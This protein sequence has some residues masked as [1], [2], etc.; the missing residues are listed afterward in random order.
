VSIGNSVTSIGQSAFQSCSGLES[1]TI[2]NSVT[3]IGEGAFAECSINRLTVYATTPPSG[4][5]SCGI[6]NGTCTLYVPEGS[7]DSYRAAAW[8]KDFVNIQAIQEP[9]LQ[10]YTILYV[11]KD[12]NLVSSEKLTF[13]VPAAPEFEGFTFQ[14][15]QTTMKDISDGIINIQAVYTADEDTSAPAVYTNPANPAQ[16]LI[17]NGNVYILRDGKTYTLTGQMVK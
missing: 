8:W 16:K 10:E 3:S 2:P 9:K 5:A 17:R 4:G 11:D 6:N 15:W 13:H 7:I 12:E 14:Y 1:I